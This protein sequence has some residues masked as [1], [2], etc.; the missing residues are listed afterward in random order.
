[1]ETKEII[2]PVG[3][4]KIVLKSWLTGREKRLI[5]S[6]LL[7][8]VNLKEGKYEIIG[9]KLTEMQDRTIETIV[10]SVDGSSDKNLEKILD[11]HSA[12]FDF[13]LAEINKITNPLPEEIKK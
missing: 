1:M 13:V 8:D 7:S 3:Q 10:V 5:Q 11:M 2:T 12:D 9:D 6:V 4:H